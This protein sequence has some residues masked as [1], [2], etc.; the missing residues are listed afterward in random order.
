D[1]SLE[2]IE[3]AVKKKDSY[4][5]YSIINYTTDDSKFLVKMFSDKNIGSYYIYDIREDHLTEIGK[6]APWLDET[7]LAETKSIEFKSR[8]GLT[9]QAYLTLPLEKKSKYPLMVL[10][11]PNLWQR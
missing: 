3:A 2:K 1:K 5:N 8:D 9:I 10:A 4:S 6:I 11:H 7:K